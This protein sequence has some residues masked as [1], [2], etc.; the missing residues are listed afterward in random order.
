MVNI[1]QID[2]PIE[3]PQLWEVYS[4]EQ[5]KVLDAGQ[6]EAMKLMAYELRK[7]AGVHKVRRITNRS[8][9]TGIYNTPEEPDQPKPAE[10]Q[11]SATTW[12]IETGCEQYI[13]RWP[14]RG[15]S[16]VM[17]KKAI[18]FLASGKLMGQLPKGWDYLKRHEYI[19]LAWFIKN[20]TY[21]QP[22][23]FGRAKGSEVSCS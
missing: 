7:A 1:N 18:D 20:Q 2:G 11:R 15:I 13:L 23:S 5:Q 14:K 21:Q 12:A 8:L 6:Y 9:N 22:S 3:I 4:S 17:E 10:P 16:P 19:H